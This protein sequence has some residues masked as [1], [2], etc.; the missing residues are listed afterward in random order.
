MYTTTVEIVRSVAIDRL[1][2][3]LALG[4]DNCTCVVH[5]LSGGDLETPLWTATHKVGVFS[6]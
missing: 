2:V 3:L 5:D 1:G 4:C 6:F